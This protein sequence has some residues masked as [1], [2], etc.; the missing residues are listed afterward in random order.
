MENNVSRCNVL[1]N[2]VEFTD[3]DF[4]S[5]SDSNP[6]KMLAYYLFCLYRNLSL[7]NESKHKYVN[8]FFLNESQLEFEDFM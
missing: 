8:K 1:I 7:N 5:L 3:F 4:E 2:L 6:P